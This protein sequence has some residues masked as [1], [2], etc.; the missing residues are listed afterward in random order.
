MMHLL[1]FPE[2]FSMVRHED[3]EGAVVETQALQLVK[4]LRERSIDIGNLAV[5][6]TIA[7]LLREGRRRSVRI[8]RVEQMNPDKERLP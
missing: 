3:D 8:M 7:I 1:V 4:K 2:R 5:V 6:G